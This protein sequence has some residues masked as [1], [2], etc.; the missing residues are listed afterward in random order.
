MKNKTF[1]NLL[2]FALFFMAY[3]FFGNLYEQIVLV[4]NQL[5]NSYKTM[6]A[7]QI[8]FSVSN[9]IYYFV[10]FTQLAV[11]LIGVLYFQAKEKQQKSYLRRAGI[12]GLLSL[13][14]TVII[15]T[16]INLKLFSRDLDRLRDQ[17]FNLSLFWLIGNAI[18]I[19][20]VGGSVYYLF[21][22]YDIRQKK[23]E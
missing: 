5:V 11:V 14:I 13:A 3:W 2:L 9:P 1:N 8:Y 7:Y 22:A 21:N 4:P 23:A 17:L 6:K 18:R 10:P 12:F 20:L 16:Q 19:C 15:V